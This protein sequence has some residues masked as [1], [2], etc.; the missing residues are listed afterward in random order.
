VQNRRKPS[1]KRIREIRKKFVLVY[2]YCIMYCQL[3]IW[4]AEVSEV[5]AW[6]SLLLAEKFYYVLGK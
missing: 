2:A 1:D 6:K 4:H 5:W 3:Q